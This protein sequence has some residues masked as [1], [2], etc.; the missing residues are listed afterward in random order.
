MVEILSYAAFSAPG[1]YAQHAVQT[2]S[3]AGVTLFWSFKLLQ[4][5]VT[6]KQFY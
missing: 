6:R 5:F 2:L 3:V 1:I 4:D